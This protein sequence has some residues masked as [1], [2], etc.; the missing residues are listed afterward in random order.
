MRPPIFLLLLAAGCVGA[1]TF[2]IWPGVAPGSDKWTQKETTLED[3][4]IGKVVINVVTP[5]LTIYLP[6]KN[7]SY[8]YRRH[9]RARWRFRRAR[10]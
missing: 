4:P 6:A 3:T 8:R 5:T 7:K 1:Q 9:Y 10:H 2:N